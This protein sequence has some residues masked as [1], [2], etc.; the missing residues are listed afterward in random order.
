MKK[1]FKVFLIIALIAALAAV[2]FAC[3]SNS[4]EDGK[5]GLLYKMY[6]GDD[7]YTVYGYVAEDGVTELDIGD[8][9]DDA[10]GVVIKRIKT[11][12][13]K[14]N[15]TIKKIIVPDTV[16]TIDSGAFA[17]MRALEEITLPFIGKTAVADVYFN[18]TDDSLA[19]DKSTGNERVFGYIFGS[20]TYD[21]GVP[22]EQNSVTYYIPQT[23]RKVNVAPKVGSEYGIPMHAF[24]G[25]AWVSEVN[26]SSDV[27]AIGESAFEDNKWTETIN[28]D[29]II[30][31][32]DYAFKGAKNLKIA[33]L[34]ALT[35]MGAESFSGCTAL[36]TVNV[37]T[38]IVADAF[39]GCTSLTAITLGDGVSKIG[40]RAFSNCTNIKADK[41][42]VSGTNSW[43]VG[44]ATVEFNAETVKDATYSVLLWTRA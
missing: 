3:N 15:D 24:S 20:E 28:L 5:T 39:N 19:K 9:N 40:A 30:T 18:S 1:L 35:K 6:P 13:F 21:Y 34:A 36:N 31:I 2:G 12:A 8:F 25:N 27:V 37:N 43:T 33:N 23:L 10:N 22:C 4:G 32:Y 38:D 44:S 41:I 17:K 7:F 29:G 11:G 16:E 42:T 26:L 14:D